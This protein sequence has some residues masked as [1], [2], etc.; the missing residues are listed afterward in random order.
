MIV[1]VNHD[2]RVLGTEIV[3]G[4]G[5]S[6]AGP[7]AEAIARAA[8]PFGSFTPKCASQ[9]RPDRRGGAL[10]VHPRN[11]RRVRNPGNQVSQWPAQTRPTDLTYCVMGNPVAHSRSPGS[12]PALPN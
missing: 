4:S 5:N 10:Q 6:R 3:Q 7:P 11:Q 9:G 8:G 12:T 2:G 1:T